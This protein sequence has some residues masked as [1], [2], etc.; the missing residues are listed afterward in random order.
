MERDA[1]LG[2]G[3]SACLYD[4]LM[5]CS[6]YSEGYVCK[7]CGSLLSAYESVGVSLKEEQEGTQAEGATKFEKNW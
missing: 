3:V 5:L 4:R 2:H 6:D 1:L 7:E